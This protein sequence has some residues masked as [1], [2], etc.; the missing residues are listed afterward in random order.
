M[1]GLPPWENLSV[2]DFPLR[3]AQYPASRHRVRRARLD[4]NADPDLQVLPDESEEDGPGEDPPGEDTPIRVQTLGPI[5][6]FGP[7]RY[8]S[9]EDSP[10]EDGDEPEEDRS[11]EGEIVEGEMGE[12][13]E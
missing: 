13:V 10:G 8:P 6:R 4:F 2:K 12:E 11:G 1:S 5:D 3:K 7:R 9:S